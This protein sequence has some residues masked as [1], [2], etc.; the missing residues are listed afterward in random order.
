MAS[1]AD[2]SVQAAPAKTGRSHRHRSKNPVAGWLFVSPAVIVIGV[3][4]V[5]PVFMA[6]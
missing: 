2:V 6:M 3:F 5:I 4:L 1:N